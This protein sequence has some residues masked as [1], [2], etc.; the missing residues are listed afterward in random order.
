MVEIKPSA[1]VEKAESVGGDDSR[2]TFWKR[3]L[4]LA[5]KKLYKKGGN[6]KESDASAV[7]E[8]RIAWKSL[9]DFYEGKQWEK[10]QGG[11]PQ[12]FHRITANLAKSN[13]DAIRPQLYFQNPKTKITIENPQLAPQPIPEM[14]PATGQPVIDPQT[15]QPTIRIPA[16]T[17]VAKVG[18][19]LVN[20]QDQIELLESIDNH[21]LDKMRVKAYVRRIINDALTIP[22]GVS[23]LEWCVE[24]AETEEVDEQGQPTGNTTETVA[25]QYPKFSRIKPWCF[26][27][28]VELDEFDLFQ[29]K[30]VAEIKYMSQSEIEN[31]PQLDVDFG[32]IGDPDY[33]VDEE[34]IDYSSD[35]LRREDSG[36]YKLY[37][38]HDLV[39]KNF[40]VL[41]EGAEKMARTEE[42]SGYDMVDG[43]IYTVLGFDEDIDDSFP[44][45]FIEQIQSKAQAY[46]LIR[47]AQVNHVFRFNRKYKMR[48]GN[49]D[50]D[51]INQW[52]HGADGTTVEVD[53]M[54]A[55]PDPIVDAAL[56]PD[57]Y[58]IADVLKR[59]TT[60]DLGVSAYQRSG[61]EPGVDTAFEA[62]LIQGG[63]DIKAQEKRDIV[64]EF[65]RLNV[66]KLNQILK[67]YSDK[68]QAI[69]VAGLK[70]S[71]WVEWSAEDI[72]GEFLEDVDIYSSMPFTEE[73]EK[74]QTMEMYSLTAAD[75]YIDPLK[76][77]QTVFRRMK[78][79]EDILLTEAEVMQRQQAEEA[80][81]QQI[82]AQESQAQQSR[83]IRPT[84][85]EVQRKPDMQAAIIG[86]ARR[87]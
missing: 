79:P 82:A 2:V 8:G 44:L 50:K 25:Y 31:D 18:G 36:R 27:W 85:G 1:K 86:G 74:K 83:T 37:E 21:H 77:R 63:T 76:L 39:N 87:A 5:E 56:T 55:G 61:R 3:R 35:E 26:L 70:G 34:E 53:D 14:N 60:E 57:S 67:V 6:L 73:I 4:E 38:I 68:K 80:R 58:A 28:D 52:Q 23:K 24:M 17:P 19:Q 51:A 7:E 64:R 54:T 10:G 84:E 22:Y 30:W 72:Q 43:S 29:A 20:A 46:N 62:S 41:V 12:T 42:P 81:Q 33:F 78:W 13:I 9:I 40:Y 16:G 47:S 48:K 69:Q 75:P 49:M 15:G 66:R 59:E 32:E 65:M 71:K 45:P 11:E